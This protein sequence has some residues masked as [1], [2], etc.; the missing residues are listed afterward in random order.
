MFPRLLGGLRAASALRPSLP[1]ARPALLH[2][3]TRPTIPK[4]PPGLFARL[5]SGAAQVETSYSSA[6]QYMHWIYA[7]GFMT[8]MGT[9]YASQQTTGPTFL[10]TKGQTKGTLMLIHKSTA[11]ILAALV[12]P[13]I[14]LRALSK[15]P[16]ALPGSMPEHLAA[17]LSHAAFYGFM[18]FMPATGIAMGYY[19]GKGVP[20]FG[21]Y[22]FPGKADKTKE[23]G[24]FAGSM[25]KWHKWAGSYLWYLPPV[26]VAA[27]LQ[28]YFRGHAIFS[29][30][31]PG[32]AK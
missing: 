20:F 6:L 30:I 21:V 17:N 10:G 11:V 32:L 31:V 2:L 12:V 25:F 18:V 19:G 4:A 15:A 28:H 24:A 9:V 7:G 29:R 3:A 27:A 23:D 26:H 1:K 14:A 16:T 22:T 8:V 5:C 13:R